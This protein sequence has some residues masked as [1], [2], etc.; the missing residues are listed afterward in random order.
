MRDVVV[1]GV[2]MTKFGRFPE[3]LPP[4]IGAEAVLEACKDAGIAW[5]KIPMMYCT[6]SAGGNTDGQLVEAEIGH[7]GIPI[8]NVANAC[9]GGAT[10]MLLAYQAVATGLY[11]LIMAMGVDQA[12]HGPLGTARP[13]QPL[14]VMGVSNMLMKYSMKMQRAIH[15]KRWT[16]DQMAWCS[17]KNHNNGLLNPRAQYKI[18]MKGP[19]DVHNSRMIADPMTLYHCCPTG[20][21]AAAAILCT[22]EVARQY[23]SG[24]FIKIAGGA[25]TSQRFIRGELMDTRDVS[26]RA[27]K[28]AY[29]ITGI[30]PKDVDMVELHDNFT[31]SEVEHIVDLQLCG[32]YEVGPLMEKGH[33]NIDGPLPVSP[34]G[35]LLAKGHP[36]SATGVAQ[37]AE[38]VWQMKG[39][40]GQRQIKDPKIGLS[41]LCGGDE[42]MATSV[43]IT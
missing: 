5:N 37:I 23:T 30:G 8:I 26:V 41:H 33:F 43:L 4:K 38:F 12:P 15:D 14:T 32:E 29:E 17:V 18:P 20:D 25:L 36:T 24:P 19:E 31:V 9:A 40:A 7:I 13:P 3:K 11:D 34:S 39:Q 1:L 27:A 2:G 22:E 42:G 10:S 35:G 21:G 6:H 16:L 28:K